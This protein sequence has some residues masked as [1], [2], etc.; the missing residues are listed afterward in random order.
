MSRNRA[1]RSHFLVGSDVAQL[2]TTAKKTP[3]GKHY[4]VNGAK[5]WITQGRWAHWALTGVRTGGPGHGGISILMIDLTSEGIERT[6]MKNSGVNS[7]GMSAHPRNSKISNQHNAGST[8]IEFDDVKVPVEN[9][10]GQE[11]EGF[12]II[13][14]S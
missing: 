10:I 11:G 3:D 4:I 6:K 14:S 1:F 13:M 2:A 9:L 12:K 5:K 7:S 8:F